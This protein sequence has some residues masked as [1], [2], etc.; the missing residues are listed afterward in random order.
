MRINKIPE[1]KLGQKKNRRKEEI[2][3]QK[4]GGNKE[5]T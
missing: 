4:F 1:R 5:Q 2:T 3:V